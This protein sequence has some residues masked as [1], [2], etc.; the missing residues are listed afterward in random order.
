MGL[1][2]ITMLGQL[3]N[4]KDN[5]RM[6]CGM[7]K[8]LILL[9]FLHKRLLKVRGKKEYLTAKHKLHI[10]IKINLKAFLKMEKK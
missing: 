3:K 10:K 1:E 5:G 9:V 8:V 2:F 4:I 6:M 7:V